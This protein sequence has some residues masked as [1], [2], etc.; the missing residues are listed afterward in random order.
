MQTPLSIFFLA[1]LCWPWAVQ[2]WNLHQRIALAILS[3]TG[4]DGGRLIG[5]FMLVAA[6]LSMWMTNTSTTMMLM[7]IALSVVTVVLGS[8]G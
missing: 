7:P 4:T 6:L 1:P 3:R 5:G 2:R 8:G